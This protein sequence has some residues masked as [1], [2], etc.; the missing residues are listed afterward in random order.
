M[1]AGRGGCRWQARVQCRR[2]PQQLAAAACACPLPC[3]NDACAPLIL[4]HS[5]VPS[6]LPSYWSNPPDGPPHAPAA[7]WTT[8]VDVEAFVVTIRNVAD[9]D[10]DGLLQPLLKR[11]QGRACT[12]AVFALPAVQVRCCG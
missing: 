3:H 4:R 5:P 2:P 1:R 12:Y 10:K 11:W 8:E 9:P 6:P 7:G